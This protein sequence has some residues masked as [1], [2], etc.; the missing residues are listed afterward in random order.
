M[1]AFCRRLAPGIFCRVFFILRVPDEAPSI[2]LLTCRQ[3]D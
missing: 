2:G 1:A 3:V